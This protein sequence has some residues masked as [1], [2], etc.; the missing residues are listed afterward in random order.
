MPPRTHRAALQPP[1]GTSPR[2]PIPERIGEPSLIQHVVYIIKENR[3]YDQVFGAMNRGNGDASL[4][5]FGERVTP[6]HH[7]LAQE[8]VLLDNTYCCGIL[9]ADGHQW[10]MTASSTDYMEKSFAGFPRSYPDGMGEDEND[11]LAYAP[12]GFLWDNAIKHGVTASATTASSWARRSAGRTRI[13]GAGP[14]SPRATTPGRTTPTMS[15]SRAG[16]GRDHPPLLAHQL[17]RLG[18]VRAG[19]VSRRFHPGNE[20]KDFEA[21]GEFP[22]LTI[23]C[24]PNDHTSGTSRNCPTPAACVADNDLAFGR[25]VE[26]LSHSRFWKDMAIF[27][28]EDDPQD[29]WDHVSGYRT[30]AYVA[31]APTPDA[32]PSSAPSTTPPAS[33]APWSR[34]SACRP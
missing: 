8:F 31:S 30:T 11:A 16:R 12:S 2:A 13:A 20:L 25:I 19:S 29:G 22:Q 4:C 26:A 7:K 32:A 10:S 5:I 18:D 6:N 27:A 1:G 33:S 28:I 23:I 17:R 15:S 21:K 24:L 34:S 9:S 3:T 14:A